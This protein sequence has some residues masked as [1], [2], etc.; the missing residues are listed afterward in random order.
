MFW[1]QAKGTTAATEIENNEFGWKLWTPLA[2]TNKDNSLQFVRG[3]HLENVPWFL[4][5]LRT[6]QITKAASA[7][8]SPS[9][10]SE[11]LKRNENRFTSEVWGCGDE[12]LFNNEEVHRGPMNLS[13]KLIVSTEFTIYHLVKYVNQANLVF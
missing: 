4:D 9:I 3:S 12:I 11:W 2:G 5:S 7:K 8:G 1:N 13:S 10:S 6:T